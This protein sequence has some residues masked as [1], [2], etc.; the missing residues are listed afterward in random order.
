MKLKR[1]RV[2][3]IRSYKELDISFDSGVTVVSG[4][5]GSGKSSLLEAC[6]SGLF[7]SKTLSTGFVLADMIRKGATTA[8]L[9]L[10]FEQKG[11]DYV[12]EQGFRYNPKNDRA[13]NTKSVFSVDGKILVDQATQ[14]YEAVRA[15][16]NM[17]E[18]AYKNC[19]YIRQGEVDVLINAKTVDR[20]RMIDDLLQIGKLE[21]YRGRA[22]S[23]RVA[24]G[25]LQ[26][27]LEGRMKD[28]TLEIEKIESTEPVKTLNGLKGLS[29]KSQDQLDE[30]NKK[31]DAAKSKM[32]EL[33]SKAM[34]HGGLTAKMDAANKEIAEFGTKKDSEFK[35]IETN[36][37]DI[38]SKRESV[39]KI[40]NENAAFEK[41]IGF[42]GE[43]INEVVVEKEKHE[44]LTLDALNDSVNVYALAEKDLASEEKNRKE[45]EKQILVIQQVAQKIKDE[46]G[47]TEQ[48]IAK[49]TDS[50][51]E[52]E[53]KQN[54]AI[55][56]ARIL[57]FSVERLE[58]ID[59]I[60]D[61][62]K[63]QQ[64]RLHGSEREVSTRIHELEKKIGTAREL[65]AKGMCP[66]CG[67]D[68]KGSSI[69][70]TTAVDEEKISVLLSELLELKVK[71]GDIEGKLERVKKAKEYGKEIADHQKRSELVRNSLEASA[72]QLDGHKTRLAEEDKKA[73]ELEG[74]RDELADTVAEIRKNIDTLKARE[75]T[76]RKEHAESKKILDSAK[77]IQNNLHETDRLTAI[78]EKL[79][80]NIRNSMEKIE[81]IE[82]QIIERRE[83]LHEIDEKLGGI[84]INE[85]NMKL[86]MFETAHNNIGL[87]IE[88]L[89]R[90]KEDTVKKIGHIE[91][92]IKRLSELHGNL[93][94]LSNK[95]DYLQSAYMDAEALEDMYMRIRADLRARNI[96]ALD[97]LLNEMFS[98]MYSNNA[99]SHIKLDSDYNLTVYEKNGIPL[100][101]KLLSGGE[102]AI[103]NLVLRCA[104]YRLLALGGSG[105]AQGDGLPPLIFDEPTV[106]LDRGHVQQLI[107]LI[108]MMRDIGVG[109]IL[110][111][112]HDES[113]IDSADH[114]FLVE[115]DPITNTSTI[116]AK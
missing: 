46:I 15:L 10:E 49:S 66:T 73:Q 84:D 39:Q 28:V 72:K 23:A 34:E 109:Q 5:N 24:V 37:E 32:D 44:R 88:K 13:S 61:L 54:G 60:M 59:D 115:K 111:V 14:T 78:I 29:N 106:F 55:E 75:E 103:F 47:S 17:D 92:E 94:F 36:R 68:L 102:R 48:E 95:R 98:F 3:N 38:R 53:E 86:R 85:L 56:N 19:V 35:L 40:K 90:E 80:G 45:T 79:E 99:Y 67:Q 11:R 81:I 21:E 77:R 110:I 18:E 42:T 71:E 83:R 57:G 93:K 16:L 101:P 100:E 6:F 65:L 70:E 51:K 82:G 31:K 22:G 20:Q 50:M 4:V 69:E 105:A 58:N 64:T 76:A 62:L 52:L 33:T 2:E 30:L 1:L 9:T 114:V 113:L 63:D 26:R 87:E 97:A 43:D 8:A 89:R 41:E 25:R 12:I 74:R 91:N 27:D 112:S 104:I 7:G 116:T 107:K 96:G 108:D